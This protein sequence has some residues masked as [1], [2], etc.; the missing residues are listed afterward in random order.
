MTPPQDVHDPAPL[1]FR[2]R[3]VGIVLGIV[4]SLVCLVLVLRGINLAEV[5]AVLRQADGRLV[6]LALIIALVN[7]A[8]LAMRW[9]LLFYP[10]HQ[11]DF[12]HLFGAQVVAQLVNMTLPGRLSP[13]AR[14]GWLSG[15]TGIPKA[16]ALST[17]VMEKILDG[18]VY[19]VILLAVLTSVVLPAWVRNAGVATGVVSTMLMAAVLGAVIAK[20]Q[21]THV[22]WQVADWVPAFHRL[23]VSAAAQSA[24]DS[25]DVWR[26][27]TQAL[28]LV[29]W[30]GIVWGSTVLLNYFALR[31]LHLSAPFMAAVVVLVFVQV[32]L[33]I[34][35]SPG[36]IGVFHYLCILALALFGVDRDAALGYAIVLHLLNF[37]PQSLLGIGFIWQASDHFG[38]WFP[39]QLFTAAED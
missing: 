5:G 9:G 15:H 7:Y 1:I 38:Y 33:R 23:R 10:H 31:A 8:A 35:S 36:S 39:Q 28:R 30:S 27:P 21:L 19:L 14:V 4:I 16:F 6:V 17:I 2:R 18:V 34:P 29:A 11:P 13:L 12:I 37:L 26:H 32:G 24:L 25:L 22:I 3:S 20:A